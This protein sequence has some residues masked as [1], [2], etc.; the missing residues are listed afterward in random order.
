MSFFNPADYD[1]VL[2]WF[3]VK[4]A[5]HRIYFWANEEIRMIND[6]SDVLFETIVVRAKIEAI[7]FY[8]RTE[9]LCEWSAD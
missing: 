3:T 2:P 8:G 7:L 6:F 4:G 1:S 5:C 9:E